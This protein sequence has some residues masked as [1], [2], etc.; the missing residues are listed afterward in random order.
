MPIELDSPT[1]DVKSS[2]WEL[3]PLCHRELRVVTYLNGFVR[4]F[5]YFSGTKHHCPKEATQ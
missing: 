2:R 5:D 3:C 4:C 1:K